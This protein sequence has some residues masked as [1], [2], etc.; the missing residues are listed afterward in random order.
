MGV[1]RNKERASDGG[2]IDDVLE[3]VYDCQKFRPARV[4]DSGLVPYSQWS[5]SMTY[6]EIGKVITSFLRR[7]SVRE[8]GR[9]DYL[10]V[11][12]D[13]FEYREYSKWKD[14]QPK[15]EVPK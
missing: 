15:S 13:E 2:R 1:N 8:G 5:T 11:P 7:L 4:R 14:S 3:T 9:A 6:R 10:L 12:M